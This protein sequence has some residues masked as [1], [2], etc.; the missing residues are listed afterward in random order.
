MVDIGITGE[1]DGVGAAACDVGD[2]GE[3]CDAL[4]EELILERASGEL[5]LRAGAPAPQAH[6]L[7]LLSTRRRRRHCCASL[8]PRFR[9]NDVL[10][11]LLQFD[12]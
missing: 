3:G 1:G 10:L 11:Y 4:R 8:F 2:G 6:L 9:F 7:L 5:A 12:L